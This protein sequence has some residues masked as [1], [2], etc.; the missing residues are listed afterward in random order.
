VG[1]L[2]E[3]A[4]RKPKGKLGEGLANPLESLHRYPSTSVFTT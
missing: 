3:L 4:A 2:I 1:C